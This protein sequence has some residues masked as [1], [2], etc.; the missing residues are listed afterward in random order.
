MCKVCENRL[1]CGLAIGSGCISAGIGCI[2]MSHGINKLSN[3]I[4]NKDFLCTGLNIIGLFFI[5]IPIIYICYK[6]KEYIYYKVQQY[7]FI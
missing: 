5:S 7:K 3:T 6:A 4:L 1:K 2:L